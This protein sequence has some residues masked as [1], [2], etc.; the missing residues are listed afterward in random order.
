[1]DFEQI[2]T[3]AVINAV[4]KTDR[5]KAFVNSND[6]EPSFDGAIYIYDNK[7]YK[8]DNLKRVAIQVKGKGVKPQLS[9][10][11]AWEGTLILY[12]YLYSSY[13]QYSV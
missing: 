6:K 7:I 8:K 3:T 11:F 10:L 9:H 2:G 1:M 12:L 4:S 13:H 5:L